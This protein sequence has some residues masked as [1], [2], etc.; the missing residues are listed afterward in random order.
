MGTSITYCHMSQV[1]VCVQSYTVTSLSASEG[2]SVISDYDT[3]MTEK[4]SSLYSDIFLNRLFS[5][6]AKWSLLTIQLQSCIHRKHTS[7]RGQYPY[8]VAEE[9]THMPYIN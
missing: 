1:A 5:T 6:S 8:R 3:L 2:L 4:S 9:I 7:G